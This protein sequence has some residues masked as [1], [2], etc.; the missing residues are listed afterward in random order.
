MLV[1]MIG[2]AFFGFPEPPFTTMA[3]PGP[4]PDY[5]WGVTLVVLFVT[6]YL[7]G[8]VVVRRGRS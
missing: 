1:G 2:L 4:R 6:T 5:V 7:V 3:F 8:L